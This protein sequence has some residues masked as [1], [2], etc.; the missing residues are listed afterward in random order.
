[1][2]TQLLLELSQGIRNCA[3]FCQPRE[4]RYIV[5]LICTEIFYCYL[6][7]QVSTVLAKYFLKVSNEAIPRSFL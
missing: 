4:H 1:M 2:L 7:L 3:P 5:E 6:V